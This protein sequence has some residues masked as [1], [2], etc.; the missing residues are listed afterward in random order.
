MP[1]EVKQ[2]IGA[3]NLDDSIETIG[4][5][6]HREARNIEFDGSIPNRRVKV[7]PGN[8]NKPNSLLPIVG[9]NKTIGSKYDAINKRI[10]IFNYNSFGFHGIYAFN[11]IPETFQRLV[12]V[13]TNTTGDPLAFSPDIIYNI[14]IIY[15]DSTQ[16]DILYYIDTLG[17]PSKI[18]INRALSN[19]Y[20]S[21][22]R[23]FL[24]VAKE[25]ADIPPV[26]IPTL[27]MR[28]ARLALLCVGLLDEVEAAIT[29]PENRIW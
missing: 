2:L 9:V 5:G 28:Q 22:Q 12:L 17:R 14:D 24:D 15:G 23:S 19:G 20:G 11:T 25:P 29:T 1:T 26:V 10:Y 8:T 3:L 4:K 18:N 27:T 6:F 13:G 21:I 16:G 7:R